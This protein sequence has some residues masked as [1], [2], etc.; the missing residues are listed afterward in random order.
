MDTDTWLIDGLQT[1]GG[2]VEP[3]I[4]FGEDVSPHLPAPLGPNQVVRSPIPK[5]QAAAALFRAR[6]PG[7]RTEDFEL[8]EPGTVPT[9]L[10]FG[11]TAVILGGDQAILEVANPATTLNGQFPVSGTRGLT[12]A[13][14]AG[15]GLA[16]L[17]FSTPQAGFGFFGTDLELNGLTVTLVSADGGQRT[18][19]VPVTRP[20]GSG[21][22]FFYGVID[23]Q[24]PFTCVQLERAGSF[25]DSFLFDDLTIATPSEVHA[26]GDSPSP[27][28]ISSIADQATAR[29]TPTASISFQIS[30]N[31]TPLDRLIL[32]GKCSD[33]E[34]VPETGFTF[35][36]QG[37]M[38]SL[39]ITPG[40][41]RVGT[42]LVTI[43]VSD[44]E[45]SVSTTLRL[46]VTSPSVT[47]RAPTVRIT[48]PED[49]SGLQPD[50]GRT[51]IDVRIQVDARDDERLEKVEFYSGTTLIG[52]AS[53]APYEMV[54][55][56]VPAGDYRLSAVATDNKGLKGNSEVVR[57]VVS[58][59][60]EDV[61][62]L[63]TGDYPELGALREYLIEM[64]RGSKMFDRDTANFETLD[65]FKLL[66]VH[67]G[68]EGKLADELVETFLRLQQSQGPTNASNGA[69]AHARGMPV[70]VIGERIAAAGQALTAAKRADWERFLHLR[71][72]AGLQPQRHVTL[73]PETE[74][75]KIL[76]GIFGNATDFDFEREL[77][78]ATKPTDDASA[79][80]LATAGD[81]DVLAV[82]PNP[83]EPDLGEARIAAQDFQVVSGAGGDSIPS[84][85][86]LFQ[87]IVCWLLRCSDCSNAALSLGEPTQAIQVTMG[88]RFK[89][90]LTIANNGAC[91]AR[92]AR[93]AV[94]VPPGLDFL[95]AAI[96]RGGNWSYDPNT[97]VATL[98]IGRV[99]SGD[100]AHVPLTLEFRATSSGEHETVAE[101]MS[102]NT[103][104]RR[105]KW[106]TIVEPGV[107]ATLH[108][109]TLA[110]GQLRLVVQGVIGRTYEVQ[111]TKTLG[112][113]V[114]WLKWG[115]A[116]IANGRWE[117]PSFDA[118]DSRRFFR[119]ILP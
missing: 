51:T 49:Y 84:R 115:N 94:S 62:I 98:E 9:Q 79:A 113:P 24:N 42:N 23:L 107:Q 100:P 35:S 108:F 109:E 111:E 4:Y 14:N 37:S 48:Q 67:L 86:A 39:I 71:T 5:S 1:P 66:M 26:D 45:L 69:H 33:T 52:I 56:N 97:R 93:V 55:R 102:N 60:G 77:E 105:E 76:K 90:P 47:N 65:P 22:A 25:E 54:W 88:E 36:G 11:K 57:I 70:F 29:N 17:D 68:G 75:F 118:G 87:N 116:A 34:L 7:V 106:L 78:S 8:I 2:S 73:A 10:T 99:G 58:D 15:S 114:P 91:E 72:V 104:P 61:A 13:G 16:R 96:E 50:D 112:V 44:G 89:V 85:K 103:L 3:D 31:D 74:A 28:S 82:Y 117:S 95:G 18:L 27:P 119:A 59:Q 92:S 53:D 64:G 81:A 38:R 83:E 80:I 110:G 30:D 101:A 43:T 46:S 21:G 20:Q 19:T 41:N 6:L 63:R 40:P 12:I 32:S